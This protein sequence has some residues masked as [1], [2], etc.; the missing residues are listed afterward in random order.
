MSLHRPV[1]VNIPSRYLVSFII[2]MAVVGIALPSLNIN[3]P[4]VYMVSPGE[5]SYQRYSD[6]LRLEI[7]LL[8]ERQRS[9]RLSSYEADRLQKRLDSA[10][11]ELVAALFRERTDANLSN[12]S[13]LPLRPSIPDISFEIPY[14]TDASVP[15]FFMA[16]LPDMSALTVKDR[17]ELFVR[18]MLPLI[19]YEN[20]RI[21]AQRNDVSQ[22]AASGNRD[23]L[24]EYA[25]IYYIR[26]PEEMSTERLVQEL[27]LRVQPVPVGLA[28]TQAAVESG[29]GQSRFALEGNAMFGQWVWN[30]KN[31]IKA[32]G[33]SVTVRRFPDLASSVRSYMR[34]LNTHRA[35]RQFRS[36]RL[37]LSENTGDRL[38]PAL[39]PELKSYA[40]TGDEYVRILTS[41]MKT[42]K[43]NQLEAAR[44]RPA[45]N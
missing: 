28:L 9:D 12:R 24:T 35:Y 11:Q 30:S 6:E 15:R 26:N 31:G 19:L 29:W 23:V 43:F 17:K 7:A 36:K 38:S 42:N 45:K 25:E 21:T 32:A 34:N 3:P 39:V 5:V 27:T 2:I 20:Q 13:P 44:L 33:S 37:R 14:K 4:P 10:N 16:R 22:A 41:V 8:T 40:E 1:A 18:I